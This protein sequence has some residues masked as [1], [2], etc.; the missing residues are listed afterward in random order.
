MQEML[1]KEGHPLAIN[2]SF[3]VSL[4]LLPVTLSLKTEKCG[5]RS[6]GVPEEEDVDLEIRS[7]ESC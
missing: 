5:I 1:F 2:L 7:K 3:A 6:S 4:G